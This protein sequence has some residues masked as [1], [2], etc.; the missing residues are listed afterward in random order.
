M[1]IKKKIIT[2]ITILLFTVLCLISSGFNFKYMLAEAVYRNENSVNSKILFS[3]KS[4]FYDEKFYLNIYAPSD[5]IYYTLDGSEPTKKSSRYEESL[6]I[7]DASKNE[8]TNSMRTDFSALFFKSNTE[9]VVPD[10]LIEKCTILKVA[11]Y[12]QNGQ[13][14]K[15][16][17]RVYFIGYGDK[18]G[19]SDVNIISI[20][21]EP[22]D[23]FS[24]DRGIYV[25]GDSFEEYKNTTDYEQI[26]EYLWGANYK[27]SGREWERNAHIQVFNAERELVLSQ[28]VGLRIQGGVS[29]AFYPKSLNLYARDVYGSNQ[30]QY[31]FFGTGYYP[32]RV[33]LSSGGNDYYGKIRDRIGAELTENCDFSTMN[34]IPYVLFLNGEYWGFYY[35]TEKYDENYIEHYYNIDKD[36][37]VI[38]KQRSLE[39]GKPEDYELYEEMVEFI[40][41]ADMTVDENYEKACSM[42]DIDSFIDYYAAEIYMARNADWPSANFAL[43][44]SSKTSQKPYE[45][46]KWR[47]MLFDV[48]TSALHSDLE[49]HDTLAYV[50]EECSL[51]ANLSEN[52]NFR[53]AFA[54]KLR[55]M[56]D[57]YFT[58]EKVEAKLGAY[59]LLM[60]DPMENHFQRFF[61][62]D[63][64]RFLHESRQVWAFACLR[65]E[66]IEDMLERN[67]FD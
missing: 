26:Q 24:S 7:Y 18:S 42:I 60:R 14:S 4:G 1:N 13:R 54:N 35:L 46:G 10:Y 48:N 11:Y 12:D 66:H 25:L 57:N 49:E 50:I 62:R 2:I 41:S 21:A 15:T 45:D 9:Y 5:E 30:M 64:E 29:R 22:G 67:G 20:T 19:Y 65:G 17:E 58:L 31:D 63:N 6:L 34:Y 44:R 38:I 51:F 16:E 3:K 33:T 32:Q 39:A 23:L 37:V 59:E 28:N 40:E 47:W 56:R 61:G 8:N 27:H 52:E 53:N 55:E 36:N 43:W